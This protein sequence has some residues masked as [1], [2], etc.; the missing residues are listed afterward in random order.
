MIAAMDEFDFIIVGAGAAGCTLAARLSEDPGL[1]VLLL[2]AGPPDR[3]LEVRLPA[4]FPKL[5][6][7]ALDWAFETP[8]EPALD[9]RRVFFPR[10]RT[11]GGSTSINA[12]IYTRGHRADYAAWADEAG[13]AWGPDA[14][15]GRFARAEA[16]LSIQPLR[17]P[18][19][20]SRA[21]VRAA[22]DTAL[23]GDQGAA[24]E[25]DGVGLARV[26]QKRGRRWSAADAYLRPVRQRPNLQTRTDALALELHWTDDGRRIDGVTYRH[27]GQRREARACRE[28]VLCAGAIGTPHLLLRSGIGPAEHLRAHGVRVRRV[29]PGV[30]QGLVDHPMCPIVFTCRA[31]VSLKAAES[32]LQLLR[33]L[34]LRRGML[35]S[36]V[37]EAVG[38]LRTHRALDAPDLELI[39][40]PVTWIAQALE[41]P[42]RH[43]FTIGVVALAPAS[44]GQ[45]A[46]ASPDPNQAPVIRPG[47]LTD[48]ADV[49]VLTHGLRLA[50][51][52]AAHPALQAFGEVSE[53]PP[54]AGADSDH[55]AAALR[56]VAQTL[57]HPAASCRMGTDALAVV[58]PTLRVH[59]LDG[60][61]IADASAMPTL[62][63][64]PPAGRRVHDR[65]ARRRSCARPG[66][67]APPCLTR[68]DRERTMTATNRIAA[69]AT[70]GRGAFSDV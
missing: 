49:R 61:R 27:D 52:L 39:F 66:P 21:F 40:A 11:L 67:A 50:R 68:D 10:G 35:T 65:R 44:R 63:R 30:G 9:G 16:T 19:P 22:R 70:A 54:A 48:P 45:V 57:Y 31:P 23:P 37:G 55:A 18:N 47:Y 13:P 6:R 59:G 36:N 14:L 38:F 29:L 53:Q 3:K 60:L 28:V 12:M 58:D 24:S 43:G 33:Y 62:P 2:E 46:L 69:A 32:P 17:D 15:A 26:T 7:S 41:P 34:L 42:T 51:R 8:P 56:Q 4:A 20:L 64:A 1:R 5:F 25:R